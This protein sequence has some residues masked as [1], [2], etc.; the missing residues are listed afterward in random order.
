MANYPK[1]QPYRRPTHINQ[2]PTGPGFTA[3]HLVD[4]NAGWRT[5]K[6]VIDKDKCISCL[7]CY[8]VCPDG[9]IHKS[10][11]GKVEIDYDYC[12][13]CGVCAYECKIKAITM[14]KEEV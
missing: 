5:F 7:R 10:A 8:I 6:P 13:G 9:T 2:F 12:K 11:D 14:V 4:K 3:G 1:L